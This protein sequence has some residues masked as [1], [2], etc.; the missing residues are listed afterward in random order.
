MWST[1]TR[2]Q[3][4]LQTITLSEKTF[5]HFFNF[6]T[7][8]HLISRTSSTTALIL[9]HS[10]WSTSRV[11][12]LWTL[13]NRWKSSSTVARMFRME[14]QWLW[15][16]Y[17]INQFKRPSSVC[18]IPNAAQVVLRLLIVQLVIQFSINYICRVIQHLCSIRWTCMHTAWAP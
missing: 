5:P 11:C 8:R 9:P 18:H 1:G 12:T 6:R 3:L 17:L 10:V 13:W 14:A 15:W 16:V 7:S 2:E 4:K